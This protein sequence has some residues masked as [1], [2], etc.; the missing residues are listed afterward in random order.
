MTNATKRAL[1]VSAVLLGL[2][3]P[4][5]AAAQSM[6]G[7]KVVE[8]AKDVYTMTGA[9]SNASFVVT[10]EGVLVF[11]SDIRNNDL[12]FIRKVTDKKV[13]YLFASHASGDHSTGA[14]YFREDKPVYIGTRDQIRA[15][16]QNELKEFNERKAQGLPLY[17]GAELPPPSLG[18]DGTMSV[19]MGGLTFQARAEGYGHT[20]G[21]MTMYIPQ[22]RVM[23]MGDLLNNEVHP[24]QAEAAG[25]FFANIQGTIDILT[26]IIDRK[27]PVDTYVPGHGAV[28]VGRGVQDVIDQRDYFVMMRDEV[29]K[30]VMAGKTLDQILKEF[31]VPQRFAHYDP[32]RLPGILRLFY[33]QLIEKGL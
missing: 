20:S 8:V 2:A 24:G 4:G 5:P 13:I 3:L 25:V 9:G 14:W 15:Y 6:P 28:H 17:K 22:R 29:A 16:Y 26:R 19:L 1:G 11:D 27:L 33:N 31:K 21:D 7:R 30:M 32:G 18:F 12:P 10:D 23:F